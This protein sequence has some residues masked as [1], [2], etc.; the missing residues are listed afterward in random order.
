MGYLCLQAI[1][2]SMNFI[3]GSMHVMFMGTSLTIFV[4]VL[5]NAHVSSKQLRQQKQSIITND[6][7]RHDATDTFD[8]YN[9]S[10]LF[11]R[12]YDQSNPYHKKEKPN[13]DHI[14]TRQ[15]SYYENV[16]MEPRII[17]GNIVRQGQFPFYS[18]PVGNWLC[19]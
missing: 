19:G 15:V 8:V 4:F 14:D 2:I 13:A 18:S 9:S 3:N 16:N 12:H 17:N 1:I 11:S 5:Q 7:R 6:K 10:Q